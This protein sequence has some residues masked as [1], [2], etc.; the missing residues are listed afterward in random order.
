MLDEPCPKDGSVL[1]MRYLASLEKGFGFM[2]FKSP[3]RDR[4]ERSGCSSKKSI[5]G[6]EAEVIDVLDI[7][8]SPGACASFLDAQEFAVV[9]FFSFAAIER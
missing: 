8:L 3:K 9:G 1:A 6:K 4:G 2:M 7:A 5:R